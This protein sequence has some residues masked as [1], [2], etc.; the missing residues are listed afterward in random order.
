MSIKLLNPLFQD[1]QIDFEL[2][3]IAPA[4]IEGNKD[5]FK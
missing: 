3:I 2:S 5:L 4:S 1:S